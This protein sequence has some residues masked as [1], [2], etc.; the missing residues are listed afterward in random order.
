MAVIAALPAATFALKAEI[1]QAATFNL[2]EATIPEMQAAIDAGLINSEYLVRQYTNR[3][4]AYDHQGPSL[5]SIIELNPNALETAKAL[6][7]E[8]SLSGPQGPLFGIPILLKDN[9][10]T[11]DLPTT[12]GGLILDGSIPSDDAFITQQLREA[13]AIILGKA[14]L[15]EFANFVA[16]N[17]PNGFSAVGGQTLN[18]YGPGEFDVGGSSSGPAAAIAANLAAISIGTETSGS[19]LSP[20]SNNSLVGIK[21]TV[22]L[23]SRD[24]IIPISATQ[25][26]AGPITRTV[27]DAAI[28]LGALT[29]IDPTDPATAASEGQFFDDYTPFLN[30]DGLVGARLGVLR[31]PFFSQFLSEDELTLAEQAFDD[32]ERLGAELV[33]PVEFP[34]LDELFGLGFDVLLYEFNIGIENYL[35][36][37]GT[38]A[39][40]QTLADIV[41]FNEANA[42]AAIPFGQQLFELSLATGGD[43]SDPVYLEEL[44][45]GIRLTATEG[46][47]V[48]LENL[49]LDALLFPNNIAAFAGAR[50]GYPS[51]TVPAGYTSEGEP[52]GLTFLSD[53]FSEPELIELAYAYE[54]GTLRRLPPA[55]TPAIA[56]DRVTVPE[57]GMQNALLAVGLMI[58]GVT[59][60]KR[61]SDADNHP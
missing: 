18:P 29:G 5:N 38:D 19:I 27:E 33:D 25:D 61:L 12:A 51:I 45:A 10:D 32:L 48:L 54:Q 23:I 1:A 6:D 39:P 37:L 26:T 8:R 16:F 2:L 52:F 17:M 31:D 53:A 56:G 59:L 49:D 21:P 43:L 58:I 57:S 60:R 55:S 47:D 4:A 15:T 14:N 9:I 30:S 22:G 24:G 20:A 46:V 35:A 50:P 40:A 13:G 42:E 28:L 44:A 41:A 3:I 34:N 7:L 36:S 11:F